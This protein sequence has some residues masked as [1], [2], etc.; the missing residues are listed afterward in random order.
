MGKKDVNKYAYLDQLSTQELQEL[1]RADID[2]PES[3][4]DE[5]IFYI[6]EVMERRERKNPSDDSSD[7]DRCWNEFQT[8]Y[9]T[10]EGMGRSLYPTDEDASSHVN[11]RPALRR[12]RP[13]RRVMLA[14]ATVAMITV[15]LTV[16]VGGY[17]SIF[18][19]LGTWT[20][21][22]FTMISSDS[23]PGGPTEDFEGAQVFEE[24][25]G[26]ELRQ[27]LA[28]H[29][30]TEKVVPTWMPE[31]FKIQGDVFVKEFD[32]PRNIQFFALYSDGTDSLSINLINYIGTLE[33]KIYE[34]TTDD[35][36]IYTAGGIEHHLFK[37]SDNLNMWSAAWYNGNIECAIN[38]TLSESELKQIIDSIYEG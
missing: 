7:L 2:S 5:A 37:G 20:S 14:T 11:P 32:S 13:L 6:L 17:A 35:P 12:H 36:I 18:E 19:M 4:D 33:S 21:Q 10:P 9:N 38:T 28:E 26:D 29:G 22:Q 25:A 30:I 31:R 8:L 16:P 27:I 23:G 3:G 1:L 24:T 15:F 34:K